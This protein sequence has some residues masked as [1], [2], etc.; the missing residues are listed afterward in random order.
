MTTKLEHHSDIGT[1]RTSTRIATKLEH[2]ASAQIV[3]R[4]L[5]QASARNSARYPAPEVQTSYTSSRPR[6]GPLDPFLQLTHMALHLDISVYT[7]PHSTQL[8]E[9]ACCRFAQPN[10]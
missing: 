7:I 10:E 1:L 6:L 9:M 8:F 3:T 4:L 2:Q 5:H